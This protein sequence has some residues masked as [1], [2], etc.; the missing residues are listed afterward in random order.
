MVKVGNGAPSY[1][2]ELPHSLDKALPEDV[3]IEIVSEAGT[4]RFMN[5]TAHRRG[6]RN[7]MS[8][9]EIAGRKGKV[10]PRKKVL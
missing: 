3:A 9:I 6:L 1:A 8:A 10:F 7:V 5:K 2:K 4:S